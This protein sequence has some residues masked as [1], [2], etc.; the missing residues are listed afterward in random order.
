MSGIRQEAED[1]AKLLRPPVTETTEEA[2]D[3]ADPTLL[4]FEGVVAVADEDAGS[5]PY[6]RTGRFRRIIR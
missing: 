2:N 6:N 4:N 1:A 5:D 3:A